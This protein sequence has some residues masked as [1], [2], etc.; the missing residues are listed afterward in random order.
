[1]EHYSD[2]YSESEDAHEAS[3]VQD[4]DNAGGL[5]PAGPTPK[6]SVSEPFSLT[7]TPSVGSSLQDPTSVTSAG[8]ER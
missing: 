1:M 4:Q 7:I 3:Q 6:L 2:D 5:T 8:I